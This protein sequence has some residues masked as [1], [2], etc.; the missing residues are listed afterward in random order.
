MNATPT[1]IATSVEGNHWLG[2][3]SCNDSNQFM[4]VGSRSESNN[5]FGVFAQVFDSTGEAVDEAHAINTTEMGGQVYPVATY[6]NSSDIEGYLVVY[7][8]QQFP[9]SG[10]VNRLKARFTRARA[11]REPFF[12][13]PDDMSTTQPDVSSKPGERSLS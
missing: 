9:D 8:D 2:S 12:V 4:V 3:V 13:S 7:E 11:L 5:T 6:M 10:Q 1:T